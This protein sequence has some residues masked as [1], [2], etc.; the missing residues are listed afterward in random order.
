MLMD[1][2]GITMLSPVAPQI[3]LRYSS[4]AVVVTLITIVY[5]CGQFIASPLIG[6]LGDRYG[7]RPVLLVSVLGQSL[8]YLIFGLGGSLWILLLGRLIGGI[9][10]GNLATAGA[11]IADVSKPEE[12]SKNFTLIGTAWSLGL[13]LGPALG[14][15]FGQ[16]SLETPAFVAAAVAFVN[17]LL[18]FF[19]LPESLPLEKRH[20]LALSLRDFNPVIAISDMARKPGLGKLLLV[21]ALFS[22]AFNGI[23]STSALFVIQKFFA[24]TWQISLLMILAGVSVAASNTFIVPRVIPRV[25]ERISGTLSLVGLA[26]FYSAIFFAPFFWLVYPLNMLVSMMNSFIFPVL[27]TLSANRVDPQEMGTLMGVTSAV[28]SLMNVFGPLWAGVVYDNVMLGAPYWMGALIVV[29][30]AWILSQTR[31]Q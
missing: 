8:G 17:V 5:A 7:R 19:L 31:P 11:Y 27:T 1:V 16:I 6:K 9:T 4:E 23:A 24:V 2:M 14:G 28:G 29:L 22:F 26:I 20:S 30:A 10:A 15:L 3:V 25:G 13:I 12:R 21:N 18:S